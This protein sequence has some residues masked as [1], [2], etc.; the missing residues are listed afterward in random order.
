[1]GLVWLAWT[2]WLGHR[3]AGDDPLPSMADAKAIAPLTLPEVAG[4]ARRLRPS[5]A[6]TP[7]ALIRPGEAGIALGAHLT[8]RL[9]RRR[10]D[11]HIL[12]AS[13]EDV[14]VAVMAPRAGKT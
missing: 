11:G 5:L 7:V 13:L 3:P 10:R 1:F 4:R 12:Y 6:G 2:W 14:I 8:H 9:L